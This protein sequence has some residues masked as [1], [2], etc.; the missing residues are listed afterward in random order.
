MKIKALLVALRRAPVVV[1]AELGTWARD[2]T[3]IPFIE[4]RLLGGPAQ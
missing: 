4:D 1:R 2:P 3:A